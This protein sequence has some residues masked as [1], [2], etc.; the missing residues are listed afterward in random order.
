MSHAVGAAGAATSMN[1]RRQS[2]ASATA[3][4][5]PLSSQLGRLA[6]EK[7][8]VLLEPCC[9]SMQCDLDARSALQVEQVV[10]ELKESGEVDRLG[11]DV[12]GHELGANEGRVNDAEHVQPLDEHRGPIKVPCPRRP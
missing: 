1:S 9:L 8:E 7:E 3:S 4:R 2:L 12:R 10:S 6:S 11:E 5:W